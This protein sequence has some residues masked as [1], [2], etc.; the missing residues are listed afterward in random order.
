M[1]PDNHSLYLWD[2]HNGFSEII[3]PN[4]PT[5][6]FPKMTEAKYAERRDLVNR[7]TFRAMIRKE[8]PDG[9]NLITARYV[10]VIKS[11]ED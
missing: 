11:D 5:A 1:M 6:I 8:L 3:K 7:G 4:D 2:H 10:L 9:T